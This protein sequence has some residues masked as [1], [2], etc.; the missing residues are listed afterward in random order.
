MSAKNQKWTDW[1]LAWF[2]CFDQRI[3]KI[4]FSG[5]TSERIGQ[6]VS[7]WVEVQ[8]LVSVVQCVDKGQDCNWLGH[9]LKISCLPALNRR[10]EHCWQWPSLFWHLLRLSSVSASVCLYF[11]VEGTKNHVMTNIWTWSE[12]SLRDLTY[13]LLCSNFLNVLFCFLFYLQGATLW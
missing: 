10:S 12:F 1:S 13:F 6:S 9:L 4:L 7:G 2:T 8:F 3:I 11:T 5:M